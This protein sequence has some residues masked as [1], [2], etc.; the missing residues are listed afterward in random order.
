MV[1]PVSYGV[2]ILSEDNHLLMGHATGTR[3]W[4]IPKGG[5][6]AGETPIQAALRE[7]FEETGIALHASTLHDLG[8]HAYLTHKD[9]HLFFC[10]VK[11]A[12]HPLSA[13]IC[14]SFFPHHRTRL[15]T[16]EMDAFRWMN[17]H[18]MGDLCSPKL[19]N[20]VISLLPTIASL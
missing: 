9:L 15:P 8:R 10:R 3:R 4:D 1:K 13:C 19:V 6:D 17:P 14:T 12:Q 18:A 5:A 16:P 2:L 7:T 20:L 11:T